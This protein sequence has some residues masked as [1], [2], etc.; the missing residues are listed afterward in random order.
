M[1]SSPERRVLWGCSSGEA[2]GWLF[3]PLVPSALAGALGL[4]PCPPA[5]CKML[6]VESEATEVQFFGRGNAAGF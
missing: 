1:G 6:C 5:G 2:H 3:L 4:V